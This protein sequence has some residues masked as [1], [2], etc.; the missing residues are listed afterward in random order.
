MDYTKIKRAAALHERH[1]ELARGRSIG[2]IGSAVVHL[3]VSCPEGLSWKK[4]EFKL[5][6][7]EADAIL[8]AQ[9]R[10][11]A[12]ELRALGVYMSDDARQAGEAA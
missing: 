11:V 8:A 5:G 3:V 6:R 9:Q 2:G 10:A 7:S 12:D 4:L 1:E